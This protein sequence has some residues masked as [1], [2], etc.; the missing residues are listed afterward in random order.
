MELLQKVKIEAPEGDNRAGTSS[1]LQSIPF[2]GDVW[3]NYT[4][5]STRFEL[6]RIQAHIPSHME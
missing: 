5:H 1:V 3:G 4:F 6:F 2:T